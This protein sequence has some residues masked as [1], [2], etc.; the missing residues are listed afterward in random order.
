[1]PNGTQALMPHRMRPRSCV[2]LDGVEKV[3]YASRSEARRHCPKHELTYRC[4]QCGAWHRATKA[5]SAK[6]RIAPP[7]AAWVLKRPAA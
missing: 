2:R 1:L 7:S 4:R 6:R 3:V 5:R